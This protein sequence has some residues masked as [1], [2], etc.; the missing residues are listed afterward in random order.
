MQKKLII[1]NVNMKLVKKLV[2]IDEK[3]LK[4]Y[5]FWKKIFMLNNGKG[6]SKRPFNV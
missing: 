4:F 3:W 2:K 5:D 1:I 6:G